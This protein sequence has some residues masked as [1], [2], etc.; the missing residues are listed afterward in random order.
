MTPGA[1]YP[2][3]ATSAARRLE[4]RV[5]IVTGG[6][7]GIGAAIAARFAEQGARVLIATRTASHGED[8]VASIRAAGGEAELIAVDL[9]TR[10]ASREIVARVAALWGRLDILIHN[11][12]FVPHGTLRE[13]PEA[14]FQKAFDVGPGTAFWLM[15]DAHPLLAASPA[16]RIIL[17]SSMAADRANV[18]GLAAYSMVKG[19]LNAL[20]RGAALEF[21]PDGI[22]VN[23][24]APGG[25]MSA[26]FAAALSPEKIAGWASTMPLRRVG[27]GIDI[28]NAMLFL[29]S[30]DASYVTGSVMTVDGGQTLG[31]SLDLDTR[32]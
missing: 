30:D 4:G 24:V 19:A 27:E 15:R 11:A 2:A 17:T 28:A 31:M 32:A 22:T 12:A 16:G 1:L 29:A 20:V 5:A 7:R 23:A 25:T 6:G 3:P 21:G 26:S 13:L 18:H 8:V 10:A 14:D 9:G